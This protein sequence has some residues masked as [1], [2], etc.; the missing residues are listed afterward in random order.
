MS[1]VVPAPG[2]LVTAIVPRSPSTMFWRR[3]CR[4]PCRR[5]LG[6]VNEHARARLVD[7]DTR[8]L[9]M[10]ATRPSLVSEV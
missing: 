7:A 8:S 2:T 1:M 6:R 9:M 10:I 3:Q 4:Y 5:A